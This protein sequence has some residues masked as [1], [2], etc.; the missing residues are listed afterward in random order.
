[1]VKVISSLGEEKLRVPIFM[2]LDDAEEEAMEQAY[3]LARLPFVFHHLAFMPDMHSGYGMPIGGVMATDRVVVPYAVGYDIGCGMCAAPSM[4]KVKDISREQLLNAV[5]AI[6]EQIPVGFNHHK[7][8]QE[9]EGFNEAPDILIIQQE[10]E[11]AR[12]QLGTLGG[13]NHFIE[14][15][16]DDDGFLVAM[17]HS[18]SRNFGWRICEMY[19]NKAKILCERWHSQLPH[20]DLSFF[21]IETTEG[22]EYMEAMKYALRFAEASRKAM[23]DRIM[24]ILMDCIPGIRF[25]GIID[26]HHNYARWE[27]HYGKNVLVHRKGATS[28]KGN[29]MGIIPG[30][31]GSKSYIV[32]G[33]G[34]QKSFMSCSH[35]AGRKMGRSRAIETLDLNAERKIMEEKGIIHSLEDREDLQE[36]TG[37]YKDIDTVM[38]YQRDLVEIVALLEPLAV[39]KA[40]DKKAPWKDKK[41]N[42]ETQL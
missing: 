28:A 31:Q 36:A 37:A 1:M 23:M 32:R 26:V 25:S 6:K 16:R 15:Q 39:V 18:G 38:D 41:K 12:Y 3:N 17:L 27:H 21:P 42:T 8:P 24:L 34:N 9:W 40:K 11:H 4:T 5:E 14:L 2:W 35:G 10:L 19:H 13:G 33:K 22:K 20:K 7:V 30:S 29:E